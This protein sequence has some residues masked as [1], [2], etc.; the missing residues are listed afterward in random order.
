MSRQQKYKLIVK[1]IGIKK[2][3][4]II[5]ECLR[6]YCKNEPLTFIKY[7]EEKPIEVVHFNK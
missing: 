2:K 4:Q 6:S 5:K 1:L 7:S 3:T